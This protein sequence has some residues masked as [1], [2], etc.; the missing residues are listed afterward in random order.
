MFG[1]DRDG[2]GRSLITDKLGIVATRSVLADAALEG[3][4]F[5][6][7]NQANVT[8]T[9][10]M[11]AG[12]WT[13]LGIY[14]PAGSG[15]DLVFHEFGWH[16]EVVMNTEGGIGVFAATSVDAAVGVVVQGGK[17]GQGGSVAYATEGCTIAAPILLRVGLGST[18]DGA[19]S[20]IPS[21][22]PNIYKIDGSII[23]APGYG[24]FTYTFDAQ[25]SSILFHYVWEEI[26]D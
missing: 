18:M 5:S 21:L 16:Q 24:L 15:K 22:P 8:T 11:T 3:R 14:N 20:T 17:Y 7:T 12:A 4:L 26:D 1:K 9:D 13:G 23:I 10:V 19:T 6:A 25:T 2:V